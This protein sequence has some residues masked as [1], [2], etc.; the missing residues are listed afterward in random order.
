MTINEQ[1]RQ[2]TCIFQHDGVPCY[3]AKRIKEFLEE[4]NIAILAFCHLLPGNF[5]DLNPIENLWV[6]LKYRVDHQKPTLINELKTLLQQEW[7]SVTL[8]MAKSLVYSLLKHIEEVLKK[9]GKHSKY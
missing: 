1:L 6:I 5:P 3:N 4:K 8:E 7:R 2:E 9:K